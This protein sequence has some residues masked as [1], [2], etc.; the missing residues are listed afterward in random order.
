MSASAGLP[1]P[2]L[3]TPGVG[4][5]L[6]A[7]HHCFARASCSSDEGSSAVISGDDRL[8]GVGDEDDVA[9]VLSKEESEGGMGEATLGGVD[10]GEERGEDGRRWGWKGS[11]EESLG[12]S[13][14]LVSTETEEA[15]GVGLVVLG[16]VND[17]FWEGAAALGEEGGCLKETW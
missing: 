14:T 7:K 16:A 8:S 2:L 15:T 3:N 10:R 6:C 5:K 11:S 9:D 1:R 17:S 12:N 13:R 4:G